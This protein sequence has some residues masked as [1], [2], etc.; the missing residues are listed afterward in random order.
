MK[1]AIHDNA[2]LVEP[3]EKNLEKVESIIKVKDIINGSIEG[4]D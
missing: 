1:H 3:Y 2:R 4:L